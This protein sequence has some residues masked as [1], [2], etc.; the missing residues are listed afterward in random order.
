MYN[1]V[2]LLKF[3]ANQQFSSAFNVSTAYFTQ[4]DIHHLGSAAPLALALGKTLFK[5][6]YLSDI[7]CIDQLFYSC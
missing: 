4:V 5:E 2:E 1:I 6:K 3:E 7:W